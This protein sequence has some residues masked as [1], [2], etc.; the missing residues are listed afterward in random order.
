M[1]SIII[2][3]V[4]VDIC[5]NRCYCLFDS[6]KNECLIHTQLYIVLLTIAS[7]LLLNSNPIKFIRQKKEEI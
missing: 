1:E 7:L 4:F 5:Y 6:N 3:F 2:S